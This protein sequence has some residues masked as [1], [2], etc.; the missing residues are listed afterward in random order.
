MNYTKDYMKLIF[1]LFCLTFSMK[2]FA[3][4]ED[5][6]CRAVLIKGEVKVKF[7]SGKV[8]DVTKET[9]I[10]EG[11]SIKTGEKS[12]VKLVFIDQS[13]MNLGINSLVKI[14]AFRKESPGIISLIRGQIRSQVTKNYME[15]E[16]KNKSKLF[17]RTKTAAMG[18]RGTDFQVN[19]EDDNE[20][21]TLVTY[22]GK[23]AMN[24]LETDVRDRDLNPREL[25]KI[26]ERKKRVLVVKGEVSNINRETRKIDLPQKLEKKLFENLMKKESPEGK[27]LERK[28]KGP[29]KG[30][31]LDLEKK[32]GKGPLPKMG[33][34]RNDGRNNE[35]RPLKNEK[36]GKEQ[37]REQGR[38]QRS[39]EIEDESMLQRQDQQDDNQGRP[40]DER[41]VGRKDDSR[42]NDSK[43]DSKNDSKNDSKDERKIDR[44]IDLKDEKKDERKTNVKEE[45]REDRKNDRKEERRDERKEERKDE[46]K[47]ER[48]DEHKDERKDEPPPKP[49]K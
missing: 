16:D 38:E 24:K 26:L 6:V 4:S 35:R 37:G 36:P 25:D 27:I 28:E 41:Q 21:T 19:F 11:A 10:T 17:I 2:I 32:P 30:N 49:N 13:V 23:I 39:G 29:S 15:M 42:K 18:I 34:G 31:E 40:T 1:I 48:K 12:F 33:E 5:Q 22:D 3:L 7:P 20:E 44:K 8:E 9:E 47:E 45:R 43:G 14:T 46:H